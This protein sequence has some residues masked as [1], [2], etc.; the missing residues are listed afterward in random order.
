M[1]IAWEDISST[2]RWRMGRR[3][4]FVKRMAYVQRM[5]NADWVLP[6]P[7]T[8][9]SVED[10]VGPALVAAAVDELALRA[11]SVP[12]DFLCPALDPT[13]AAGKRSLDFANR[14]R[15]AIEHSWREAEMIVTLGKSFRHLL[16]YASFGFAV[17]PDMLTG[18]PK[19][20]I[21]DPLSTYPEEKPDTDFTQPVNCA[22][23]YQVTGRQIARM[24]PEHAH[25]F[26]GVYRSEALWNVVEWVDSDEI[27]T[28]VLSLVPNQNAWQYIRDAQNSTIELSRRP[29]RAGMCTTIV[30]GAVSL[31]KAYA[32]LAN[33]TN[34]V[35]LMAKLTSLALSATEK[36]IFP[37]MFILGRQNETPLL[38][39]GNWKDGRTGEINLVT[40]ASEVSQLRSTP[41]PTGM[42]MVDRMERNFRVSS[43]LAP[44]LTGETY[45]ALRTGRGIDAMMGTAVDPRIGEMQRLMGVAIQHVNSA[46]LATYK[47]YFGSKK[48][49]LFSMG[50]TEQSLTEFTPNE[51]VET[52]ANRVRYSMAGADL[53]AMTIRVG[54]LSG[55]GL[56]SRQSAREL[57]PLIDDAQEEK[58]R[59]MAEEAEGAL[60]SSL[61][62]RAQDPAGGLPPGDLARIVLLVRNGETLAAAV[63]KVQREAQERQ[64]Q[65]APQPTPEQV[66]AP[67]TMPG[68]ANPGEGAQMAAPPEAQSQQVVD[69]LT[70]LKVLA[71]AARV[72]YGGS[73]GPLA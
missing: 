6:I 67:E 17:K 43:G 22:D 3:S 64:A 33:F 40:G 13:K 49:T 34:Q 29:N 20:S 14:R 41:D 27:V 60:M 7:G 18:E 52:T 56:I 23:V 58:V 42:Q 38:L 47:G 11:S 68:I 70:R 73:A 4:E 2:V 36:S 55:S 53:D 32:R 30:L 19:I 61:L 26:D 25:R 71:Q 31:D 59:I 12:P 37:D 24:Y 5:Y 39:S 45:G 28:G 50:R 62:A 10:P 21:I 54:Q 65:M 35:E 51:H 44:A 66:A 15:K 69:G 48:F 46:V 1:T 72:P 16:G 57:H 9:S 63:E 8:E